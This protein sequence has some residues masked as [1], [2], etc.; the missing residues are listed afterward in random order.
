MRDIMNRDVVSIS[1]CE[2]EPIHIPGSIQPHGFLLGV[3]ASG[4]IIEFCSGNTVSFSGYQPSQLLGKHLSFFLGVDQ[5][6]VF[7]QYLD[8][9]VPN[10]AQ[11]FVCVIEG[12][13]FNT[14]VH[15]SDAI[16][17]L[18]MEPFPDGSLSLP[19]L[20]SQTQ[21]F[22]SLLQH[23]QGIQQ[24][25]GHIAE[26]TRVITGY[27]RVMIYR[28]D[29]HYNGEIFAESKKADLPSFLGHHYPHTDI[30]SQ[31]RELYMR[32]L[33]RIIADV[34][35]TP[36]PIFVRDEGIMDKSLDLSFSILRSVSPI[37]IQYL[38]NMGVQ[39]TLTISLVLEG[40]LWGLIACHHYSPKLLPHYTR[41]SAQLQ[42]HFLTSQIR[43][44]ETA[45]AYAHAQVSEKKL[46]KLLQV[47]TAKED[48]LITCSNV[49]LLH[50]FINA[51]G[52]VIVKDKTI[53]SSGIV[54]DNKEVKQLY[55]WLLTATDQDWWHTSRLSDMYPDAAAFIDKGAGILYHSLGKNGDCIIWF[56]PEVVKAVEWA[57][58]P[59]EA[60]IK[61]RS[62]GRLSPRTSF[63]LW[64][65]EVKGQSLPWRNSELDVA[66]AFAYAL[67]KQ[68]HLYYLRSF[69]RKLQAANA[70]LEN[71]N[72]IGAHDLNEPLRKIK[73]FSSMILTKQP[74][75]IPADVYK[76]IGRIHASGNRMQ[77]LINDLL[78]YSGLR[79][80]EKILTSVDLNNLMKEVLT[81]IREAVVLKNAIITVDPLPVLRLIHV[82]IKEL[83]MQLVMNALKFSKKDEPPRILITYQR[84][85]R[86]RNRKTNLVKIYH[87]ISIRDNGQGF[88]PA[89]KSK[90]FMIFQ[91]LHT[92]IENKGTGIGL[93][94]SKKIMDNHNGFI[95][96][97]SKEGE[98]ATFML[99]FP[100]VKEPENL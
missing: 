76:S 31:A 25:C 53:C 17:I 35:Y 32:N 3:T 65:E 100:L 72:W 68:I 74:D 50:T 42:A 6:S 67:Q 2:H 30:P 90:I 33:L 14:T 92:N 58:N 10:A 54:P 73:L 97:A 16:I 91:R 11:P 83:F 48:F 60:V 87:K 26:E 24:L 63:E 23:A 12:I 77:A 15:F 28:F 93:A 82:Q 62:N 40:R 9:Y 95:R 71:F 27:D 19:D 75:E 89:Y 69:T 52:T 99:Y 22:V 43:V 59:S 78:T 1:D 96:T 79:N 4:L 84:V 47:L 44:Q 86:R 39:A 57:G 45:E 46:N 13:S 21:K 34:Q 7:E 85:K 94:I 70:E 64:K 41:L 81:D 5:L 56:R 36:V 51:G 18:E 66:T 20:Y 8:R 37:H 29:E 61:D 55:K 98:G 88:D 49:D 80:S 38:K